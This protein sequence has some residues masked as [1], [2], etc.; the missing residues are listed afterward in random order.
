MKM[1]KSG[2]LK[3][4][5]IFS[6]YP[7]MRYTILPKICMTTPGTGI[8]SPWGNRRPDNRTEAAVVGL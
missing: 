3:V 2:I 7:P 4:L 5:M 6:V 8:S 1:G